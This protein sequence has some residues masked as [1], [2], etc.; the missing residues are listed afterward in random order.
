[1]RLD[2]NENEG[3]SNKIRNAK[4]LQMH[5]QY[6]VFAFEVEE[7]KIGNTRK[8]LGNCSGLNVSPHGS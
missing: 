6:Q 1:M 5:W 2:K 4:K 3:N 8:G 7:R